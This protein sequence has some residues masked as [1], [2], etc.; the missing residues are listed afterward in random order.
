MAG[1][2]TFLSRDWDEVVRFCMVC[3]DEKEVEFYHILEGLLDFSGFIVGT[4]VAALEGLL[5]EGYLHIY[6]EALKSS[7]SMLGC[8]GV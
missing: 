4:A 8:L 7:I 2:T 3:L 1:D 5:E 6:Q